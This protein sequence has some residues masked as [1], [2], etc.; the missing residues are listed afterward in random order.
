MAANTFRWS[1]E[2]I[3]QMKNWYE[4]DGLTV[5]QIGVR[6]GK[7]GKSVNKVLKR[8]GCCMRRRGPK[9]GPG[10]PEWKGGRTSDKEGYALIW[11][12]DHPHANH[13]GRVR[14]HRLIVEAKIGRYLKPT[15]VVH[16]VDDDPTNN[17][18]DN[19]VL[20]ETNGQH[21]AAT[22][23]GK[24]PTWTEAGRERI[25]AA[26][27]KPRPRKA[28]PQIGSEA[29][30]Q[31]CIEA[32]DRSIAALPTDGLAPLE[33]GLTPSSESTPLETQSET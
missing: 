6:V 17:S 16:H 14:E 32:T 30:A 31:A 22:L 19:L 1:P 15:E 27:R 11:M 7:T 21:L 28:T 29:D 25:L 4:K 12:P 24:C 3:E 13:Q 8:T 23:K 2:Q 26:V 18:E 33:M 10:H 5:E 20:Y 9:D